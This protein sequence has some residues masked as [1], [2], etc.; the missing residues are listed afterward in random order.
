MRMIRSV[1]WS[2]VGGDPPDDRPSSEK[3]STTS[4]D[5][6]GGTGGH[7]CVAA[8]PKSTPRR[9]G[10]CA[11]GFLTEPKAPPSRWP[12][13]KYISYHLTH[14][15]ERPSDNS[16]TTGG[17]SRSFGRTL[18]LRYAWLVGGSMLVA[19]TGK[20]A[21]MEGNGHDSDSICV[22]R[23][24]YTYPMVRGRRDTGSTMSTTDS[25]ASSTGA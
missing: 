13:H 16:R 12:R 9:D 7:D 15:H 11:E 6:H 23:G 22:S 14:P 3:M 2:V 1:R 5:L 8:P 17:H 18:A 21:A 19:Q 4:N 20:T 25:L 10:S 24:R